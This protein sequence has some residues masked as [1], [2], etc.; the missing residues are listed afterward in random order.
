VVRRL[1]QPRPFLQ[2]YKISI[3]RSPFFLV[4]YAS[5]QKKVLPNNNNTALLPDRPQFAKITAQIVSEPELLRLARIG[6]VIFG[7]PIIPCTIWRGCENNWVK[8]LQSVSCK[9]AMCVVAEQ[10]DDKS[11]ILFYYMPR[12]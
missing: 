9:N 4:N 7:R 1:Q 12:C 11:T 6:E 2:L 3:I 5:W 10:W 8:N